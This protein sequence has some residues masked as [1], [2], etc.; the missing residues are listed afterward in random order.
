MEF[1]KVWNFYGFKPAIS[2][3]LLYLYHFKTE[4]F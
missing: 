4:S 1:A 3:V 2:T